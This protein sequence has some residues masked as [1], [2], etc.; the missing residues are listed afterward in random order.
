MNEIPIACTLGAA[1]LQRRLRDM[2]DLGREA[3]IDAELADRS[4][5]LRFAAAAGIRERVAAIAEAES[6]C[7]AFLTMS[8][9]E[10]ADVV[11]LTIDAPEGAQVVLR[12]LVDA[13]ATGTMSA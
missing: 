2:S 13:F 9:A 8:V 4:A 6:Q 11:T 7:C 1:D 12:E 3:L 5:V 10:E